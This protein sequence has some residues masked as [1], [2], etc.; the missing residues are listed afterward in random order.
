MLSANRALAGY[1][2]TH[3]FQ[4][5]TVYALPFG[6]GKQ[7]LTQGAASA[8]LG[9]WSISAILSRESGTP[10]TISSSGASLNAPGNS[11]DADQVLPS[12]KILGGHGPNDPYFDPNAFAPVTDIR[13][14]TSG[15][16]I[17]RGPGLFNLNASLVREFKLT[18]RFSLQF[19]TEAY[20]LTN[21][22]QFANPGATVSNAKF[23]NGQITSYGGYDIISS[24]TGQRQIRFALRLSF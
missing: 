3:N 16:N 6:R 17:V 4:L 20:G 2:R 15:R 1:D 21:T 14:G 12:V 7:W 9:G 5:W 11:Q 8:I 23:V 24:S 13:F 19:R 10:F 22:P 18:E